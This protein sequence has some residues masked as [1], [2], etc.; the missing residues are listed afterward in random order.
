MTWTPLIVMTAV[1]VVLACT[2]L[3]RFRRRDVQPG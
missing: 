2:G 1:A 3:D